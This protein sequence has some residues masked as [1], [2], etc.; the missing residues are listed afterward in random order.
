MIRE[1]QCSPQYLFYANVHV[2]SDNVAV[3]C[4]PSLLNVNV[5]TDEDTFLNFFDSVS[6]VTPLRDISVIS[7]V[8]YPVYS[9]DIVVCTNDHVPSS[10]NVAVITS[11]SSLNVKDFDVSG[12]FKNFFDSVSK[13][14]PLIDISVTSPVE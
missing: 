2:P 3:T 5:V 13:V 7:P 4:T 11:P 1:L 6:K 8:V 14:T 9:T 12:T 10:D